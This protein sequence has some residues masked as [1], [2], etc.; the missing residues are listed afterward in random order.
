MCVALE[1]FPGSR[2]LRRETSTASRAP[3]VG[4]V[5]AAHSRVVGA[6][7]NRLPASNFLIHDA[8]NRVI[9]KNMWVYPYQQ[10]QTTMCLL[11]IFV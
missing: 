1:R 8:G 7:L 6:L 5:P 4:P 10:G 2:S 9:V 11:M 3:Q